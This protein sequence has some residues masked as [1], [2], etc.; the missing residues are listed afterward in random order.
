VQPREH[1]YQGFRHGKS[2][3]IGFDVPDKALDDILGL[4]ACRSDKNIATTL[5]APED[6]LQL[7]E[8]S[9]IAVQAKIES[10]HK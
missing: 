9:R 2:F 7:D 10:R 5:L 3:G 6:V 8:F 1:E 4:R